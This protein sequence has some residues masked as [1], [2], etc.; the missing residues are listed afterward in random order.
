MN[1]DMWNN[2]RYVVDF[3]IA[4][5]QFRYHMITFFNFSKGEWTPERVCEMADIP[6]DRFRRFLVCDDR[7]SFGEMAHI[8]ETVFDREF[9]VCGTIDLLKSQYPPDTHPDHISYQEEIAKWKKQNEE[10]V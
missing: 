9:R 5:A 3:E 8:E 2:S 6:V 1:H 10:D 4:G 7:L